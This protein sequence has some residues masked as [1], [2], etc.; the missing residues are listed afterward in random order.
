MDGRL[1]KVTVSD[2]RQR[3]QRVREY[4]LRSA[5]GRALPRYAP[6]AHIEVHIDAARMG[7]IVR[8]YSILGGVGLEDDRADTYR[9]AVQRSDTQRGSAHIHDHI[10]TGA[11]L[12]SSR[13]KN[14]FPLDHRA[15]RTLLIAGGIGIT[16][17]FAMLRSLAR[18]GRDFRLVY[19]GRS[20]EQLAYADDVVALAGDRATFHVSDESPRPRLDLAALLDAQS[21]DTIV[22]VCG[23]EAM[24]EAAHAAGA[25]LGWSAE[26][27]RSERFSAG[28]SLDDKP[29]EVQ[30]RRSGQCVPVGRD[31]TI[32]DALARAG[33]ELFS[34]CRRGECGL[35][36][37]P[38]FDAPDGIDHRD[39]YLSDDD[40]RSNESLCI[41]V[42]RARGNRLV[43]D[44]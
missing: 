21:D 32:L 15:R 1:I 3:T 12:H 9:I 44:I 28:P 29:F 7:P 40:H 25:A 10:K 22:Y 31:A 38:V 23:P 34:D 33:V 16:P 43:L 14:S 6:G 2:V 42:S 35:C 27:I 24:I 36:A 19:A 37:V 26:R 39:R 11:V 8:H 4:L 41:C 5:D 30:L 20:R 18:R 13:P 17:I